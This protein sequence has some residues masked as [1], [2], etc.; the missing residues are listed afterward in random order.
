MD[1]A[2][3]QWAVYATQ[4]GYEHAVQSLM[5]AEHIGVS[6]TKVHVSCFLALRAGVESGIGRFEF[7]QI[8]EPSRP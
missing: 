7:L 4:H 2:A 8:L 5:S 6:S 1:T 3:C